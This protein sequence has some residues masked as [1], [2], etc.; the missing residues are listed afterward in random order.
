M[1]ESTGWPPQP[2][3][4]QPTQ[5]QLAEAARQ[6]QAT[7]VG[8]TGPQVGSP[9][10]LGMQALAAG[11]EPAE[12]DTAA[13]L[14]EFR[15]LQ[16]RIS[17]LEAE[18]RASTAPAVVRYAQAILDH[19]STKAAQHPAIQADADHT[20][21]QAANASGDGGKGVLGAASHLV[22]TA[23]TAA[24]TGKP[25]SFG[26]ELGQIQTW[27]QRHARRFPHVDYGYV[28]ELAEEAALAVT[29]LAA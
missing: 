17:A 11:A 28:L 26:N 2:D 22:A 14:A 1:T 12:V 23:S 15:A 24:D 5:E 18:K 13:M 8:V 20:Y 4:P 21:G 25:G 29:K 10:D 6:L 16:A 19:L 27:V 7:N 3:P 9:V